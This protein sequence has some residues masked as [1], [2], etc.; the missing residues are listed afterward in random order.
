M[1]N[2]SDCK[3]T[4]LFPNSQIFITIFFKKSQQSIVNSQRSTVNSQL[5]TVNG[6]QSTVNSQLPT[7]NRIKSIIDNKDI[8][9]KRTNRGWFFLVTPTGFK[10]VTF[11][12]VV[13]CSIQLSYGAVVSLLRMQ[14]YN[15]F[16]NYQNI[17]QLFC[18]VF[19]NSLNLKN[20]NL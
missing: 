4:T 10:P 15:N 11:A 3:D 16:L 19:Y 14:R 17:L 13:R 8:Q 9:E 20:K 18:K 1:D 5:P 7:V 12:S 6:Q 2:I